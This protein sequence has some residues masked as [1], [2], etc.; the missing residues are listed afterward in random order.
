MRHSLSLIVAV[1]LSSNLLGQK[2]YVNDNTINELMNVVVKDTG[3][4]LKIE[5]KKW[6]TGFYIADHYIP[7][8]TF[9]FF[10]PKEWLPKTKSERDSIVYS[11][12]DHRLWS[13]EFNYECFYVF[14]YPATD[15]LFSKTEAAYMAKQAKYTKNRPISFKNKR[16]KL[17]NAHKY[18]DDD[19]ELHYG[20]SL[21]IFS[22]ALNKAIVR[23]YYLQTWDEVAKSYNG[24]F[25]T[26]YYRKDKRGNWILAF[27]GPIILM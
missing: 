14:A 22:P 25:Q 12:T 8:D 9:S 20:Y 6:N 7:W 21:P 1:L 4:F 5:Q 17:F 16:F 15:T 24:S 26:L 2:A 23:K 3:C 10:F 11:N 19:L 27:R 18:I 13:P